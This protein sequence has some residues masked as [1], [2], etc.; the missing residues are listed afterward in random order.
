MNSINKLIALS[1]FCVG[2]L[3]S[4]T[5]Q[6]Q[7]FSRAVG[8]PENPKVNIVWNRYH[9]VAALEKAAKDLAKAHPNLVKISS[10]GKSYEGRDI[11]VIE[12]TNFKVGDPDRKPGFYIDGNI[13]A[14]ELQASE[15]ALYTAWYLAEMHESNEH[16]QELLEDRVFYIVPTINPDARDHFIKKPNTMHSSRSGMKPFDDDGDGLVNED[17]FDDLD[18]DGHIT[19]MRRKTPMGRYKPHHKHPNM[20][21]PCDPDEP[22]EYELL[23]FEG[24]DRDG[25]GRVNEDGEGYYDPNRDWGWNWQPDYIQRGAYKYPFS[26]PENRA[27]ADFVLSKPNIAGAQSYHNTGGMVLRGPGAEED[28]DTYNSTDLRVYDAI[29]RKGDEM[30]PGYRYLTVYKDL[31]SVFGGE[32]DWFYGGRGIFTF[33]NELFTSYMLF[34]K[35]YR[36]WGMSTEDFYKFDELLLF[37]DAFVPWKKYDHPQFGEIEIGGFKKNY[38][39]N[40]PGFLL[41]QDAHRNMAFTLYHA[42][43]MPKLAVHSIEEKDLGGGL[44]QITATITNERMIPTHA[45]HDIKNKIERPNYISISGPKVLAGM[46]MENNDLNQSKEQTNNPEKLEVENIPGMGKVI[47]RWVVKGRQKAEITVDSAKGGL[48]SK[49]Q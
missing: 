12:V 48:V 18:G 19:Q 41:E 43:H 47:V 40:N 38:T 2:M 24:I 49:K 10:I 42:Y 34:N 15:T 33:T 45:S 32:L 23:G 20:M 21:V 11:W 46:I 9:D 3:G 44:R 13:H 14:N 6:A 25:D 16:I 27:V 5:L 7:E 4:S 36:G 35:E 22:C 39:R 30:M 8:T 26:I 29:G 37:G 28:K 31:Y 1:L 17:G